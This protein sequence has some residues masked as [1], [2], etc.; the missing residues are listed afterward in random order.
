MAAFIADAAIIIING[1]LVVLY[2]L[3]D[4]MAILV[5]LSC[6]LLIALYFDPL[7]QNLVA[8]TAARAGVRAPVQPARHHQ[9]FTCALGVL[10]TWAALLYPLPVPWLGAGMWFLTVAILWLLPA[11]RAAC[12]WRC[13]VSILTYTLVLLGFRWYLALVSAV[14][15]QDWAAI[16]GSSEEARRVIAGNRGLFTT[17]GTW[18]SWFVLPAA[19]AAYVVQRVTTN[20]MSLVNPRQTA[21]EILDA[22]RNRSRD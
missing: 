4:Q 20:P 21:A 8:A 15:P 12:L 10:W 13:K 7:V 18:A 14:S 11:E 2:W 6:V 22:I 16:I 19:H 9:I 17:I 3:V 5:S 1:Y